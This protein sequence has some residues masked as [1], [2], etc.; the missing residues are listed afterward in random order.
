MTVPDAPRPGTPPPADIAI[1]A[2]LVRRLLRGQHPDL[3]GLELRPGAEGWDCVTFRLGPEL[4]VRI[5]R[6]KE[7]AELVIHEQRWLPHLAPQ[8]PIPIPAPQRIGLPNAEFPWHWSVVPWFRGVAALSAPLDA[9]QAPRLG[10][11][12]RRLHGIATP[13][14]PPHNPYRGVPLDDRYDTYMRRL[15]AAQPTIGDH[16]ANG[17]EAVLD[18]AR[19]HSRREP[20]V[21]LHGDLHSK[22]VVSADG[23]I[24][25]IID[26]GDICT[27]DAATDLASL[28]ILFEPE[29][30]GRFWEAYGPIDEGLRCRARAWAVAFGLM[31]HDSHHAADPR[32][33]TAG[34]STIRRAVTSG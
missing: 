25:A 2:D 17:A 8:L 26:W 23:A 15:E 19:R 10:D 6:R 20:S 9:S 18:S 5:P 31:L 33:A 30:H 34:R 4:A 13:P 7:A 22:N 32:F 16:V 29:H 3:A 12:L 24:A 28:W 21:W 1:H 11:F 14:D 27:G